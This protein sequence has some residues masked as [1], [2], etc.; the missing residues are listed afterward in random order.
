MTQEEVIHEDS[1]D[2]FRNDGG[3]DCRSDGTRRIRGWF[4]QAVT[5]REAWTVELRAAQSMRSRLRKR[6]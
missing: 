2:R 5:D 3:S 1:T 4:Q 6:I